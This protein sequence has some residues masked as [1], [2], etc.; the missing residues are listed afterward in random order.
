MKIP[1]GPALTNR[2]SMTF[3][4]T[5]YSISHATHCACENCFMSVSCLLRRVPSRLQVQH[6]IRS[7]GCSARIMFV[8]TPERPIKK[9]P[10]LRTGGQRGRLV[11]G[12]LFVEQ[13]PVNRSSTS[14]SAIWGGG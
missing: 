1:K 6:L 14:L 4:A 9:R 7:A 2:P 3:A 11:W 13:G 5:L 8:A 10:L 12:V